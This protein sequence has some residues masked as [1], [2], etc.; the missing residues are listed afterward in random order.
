[1]KFIILRFVKTSVFN[2]FIL[3]LIHTVY[4][5]VKIQWMQ[6]TIN[7]SCK[8]MLLRN[9]WLK[10]TVLVVCLVDAWICTVP[11]LTTCLW[12][13]N[14][15]TQPLHT[16]HPPT[17]WILYTTKPT[18]QKYIPPSPKYISPLTNAHYGARDVHHRPFTNKL[19]RIHILNRSQ[20]YSSELTNAWHRNTG[21]LRR[22]QIGSC[23]A[24][25]HRWLHFWF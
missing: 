22:Y 7:I 2:I 15:L 14:K 10:C 24:A 18:N 1:M 19:N 11:V 13:L 23:F 21:K 17:L 12:S 16:S 25:S 8:C 20:I 4:E 3:V 5:I 9:I 6:N